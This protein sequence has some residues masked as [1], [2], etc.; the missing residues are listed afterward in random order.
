MLPAS[1]TTLSV[2]WTDLNSS[3]QSKSICA[4]GDVEQTS[5]HGAIRLPQT[6]LLI[7]SQ[8]TCSHYLEAVSMAMLCYASAATTDQLVR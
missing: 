2:S 1:E 7:I 5:N 3:G 8:N 4:A 6:P